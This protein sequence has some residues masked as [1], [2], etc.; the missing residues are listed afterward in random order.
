MFSFIITLLPIALFG[1]LYVKNYLNPY[2]TG[3]IQFAEGQMKYFISESNFRDIVCY[4]KQTIHIPLSVQY[5]Y[6]KK[7]SDNFMKEF[8]NTYVF[9]RLFG[10]P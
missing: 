3:L 7:D 2:Y 1:S 5:E 4:G 6:G 10:H 9:H 8:A